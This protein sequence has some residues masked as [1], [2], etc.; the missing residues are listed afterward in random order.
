MKNIEK[1]LEIILNMAR[2]ESHVLEF[3]DYNE[4]IIESEEQFGLSY[5]YTDL[6]LSIYDI[7][8]IS[9]DENIELGDII[10]GKRSPEKTIPESVSDIKEYL[11]SLIEK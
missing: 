10:Y 7:T 4:D 1:T 6:V 5:D 2:F 11:K 9:L 8:D 3:K